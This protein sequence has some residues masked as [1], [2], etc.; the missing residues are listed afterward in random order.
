M[1]ELMKE[2]FAR[3]AAGMGGEDFAAQGAKRFKPWAQ[4]LR[5]LLIDFAAQPLG[6]GRAL[7]GSRDC[8][9]EVPATDY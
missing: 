2:G 1:G 4:V 7:A 5:K 3:L 8:D 6:N 9:L